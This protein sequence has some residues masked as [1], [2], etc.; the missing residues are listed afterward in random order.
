MMRNQPGS[1]LE[2]HVRAMIVDKG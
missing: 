1:D 2:D